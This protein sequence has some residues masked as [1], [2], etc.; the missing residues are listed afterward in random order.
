MVRRKGPGREGMESNEGRPREGGG[1]GGGGGGG[2][3]KHF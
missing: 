1:G 3:K 2:N